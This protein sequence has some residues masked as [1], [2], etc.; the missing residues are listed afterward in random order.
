MNVEPRR[1]LHLYRIAGTNARTGKFVRS[2]ALVRAPNEVVALRIA[3]A[4]H[5][6]IYQDLHVA[7]ELADLP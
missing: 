7:A 6:S 1:T 2:V 4:G 3:V 5:A